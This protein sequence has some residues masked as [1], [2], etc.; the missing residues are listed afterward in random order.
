LII[1]G[2]RISLDEFVCKRYIKDETLKTL[3][4]TRLLRAER[5]SV[6][7]FSY[8]LSHDTLVPPIKEIA[9]KRRE[10]EE[11]LRAEAE[12]QEEL[13]LANER[14]EKE[15]VE[16]EKERKRQR[17]V[18]LMVGSVA[19]LA[20][21][22]AI[23]GLVMWQRAEQAKKEVT[24]GNF[25]IYFNKANLLMKDARYTEAK[26]EY[27]LALKFLPTRTDAKDSIARCEKM[28][29]I[30]VNFNNLLLTADSICG[31][32][33]LDLSIAKQYLDSAQVLNFNPKKVNELRNKLND[34]Y[35]AEIV[36]RVEQIKDPIM[37]KDIID[38]ALK[39]VP[40]NK[41]LDALK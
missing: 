29:K 30:E 11:E 25:L 8:E 34:L 13:R 39:I 1:E 27:E 26:P 22:F 15:R 41:K 7:G 21:A 37:R 18:I 31:V 4:E 35:V 10:K 24:E 2:R 19:V 33:I 40:D 5:N 36:N 3:V 23:F 12:R 9:D 38:N 28:G 20:L 6:E 16:R 17:K 14:A 32:N